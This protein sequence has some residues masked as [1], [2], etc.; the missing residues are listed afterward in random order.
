MNPNT[1]RGR[2]RKDRLTHAARIHLVLLRVGR[3][4]VLELDCIFYFFDGSFHDHRLFSIIIRNRAGGIVCEVPALAGFP[5]SGKVKRIIRPHS[6]HRHDMRTFLG[7]NGGNPKRPA[8]AHLLRDPTPGE[9]TLQILVQAVP[10]RERTVTERSGCCLVLFFR[11]SAFCSST[12]GHSEQIVTLPNKLFRGFG[13]NASRTE[14]D[15]DSMTRDRPDS[16]R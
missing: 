2:T 12:C 16:F 10:G 5:S 1:I 14:N 6:P 9:N 13:L 8:F 3:R 7:M 15:H 4:D 11:G